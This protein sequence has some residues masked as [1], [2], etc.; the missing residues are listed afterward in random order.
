MSAR[1]LTALLADALA[2]SNENPEWGKA[3]PLGLFVLLAFVV[4]CFF[5]FRSLNRRIRNV[6]Q[7]FDTADPAEGAQQ[8][9]IGEAA[10]GVPTIEFRDPAQQSKP[11]LGTPDT[12]QA[13][14]DE[15]RKKRVREVRARRTPPK[16]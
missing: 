14:L 7:S 5:L 2:K 6:P 8:D 12:L 1:E 16:K 15:K 13:E 4:V 9:R 10:A 3:A 11:R